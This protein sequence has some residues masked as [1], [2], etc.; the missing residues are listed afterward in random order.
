MVGISNYGGGV[1]TPD[2]STY[3]NTLVAVINAA[4]IRNL[5]HQSLSGI[6]KT[7]VRFRISYLNRCIQIKFFNNPLKVMD[8]KI[9][10]G[11]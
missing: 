6:K 11:G 7:E 2:K 3:L 1:A 4:N 5:Q 8:H 9:F 10:A